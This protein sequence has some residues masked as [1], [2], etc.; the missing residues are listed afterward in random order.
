MSEDHPLNPPILWDFEL[1]KVVNS[2]QSWG[3]GGAKNF[4]FQTGRTLLVGMVF[5]SNKN[6]LPEKNLLNLNQTIIFILLSI[7]YLL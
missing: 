2:S 1:K 3:A 4:G 5:L 6:C 7:L